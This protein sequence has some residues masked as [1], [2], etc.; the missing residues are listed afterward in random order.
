[1]LFQRSVDEDESYCSRPADRDDPGYHS[2]GKQKEHLGGER[3]YVD[4]GTISIWVRST[5]DITTMRT[6]VA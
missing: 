5:V 4:R 2:G 3:L 1:M 6:C